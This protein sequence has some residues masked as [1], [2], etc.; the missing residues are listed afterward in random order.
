MYYYYV[1][2]CPKCQVAIRTIANLKKSECP[3]CLNAGCPE[4]RLQTVSKEAFL[5]HLKN[6]GS[7]LD[8]PDD[9]LEEGDVGVNSFISSVKEGIGNMTQEKCAQ[10]MARIDVLDRIEN[11]RNKV[12]TNDAI[13]ER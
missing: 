10:T 13:E 8:V 3:E 4:G 6:T 11:L 2:N 1:C 12:L 9:F 7:L 5:Q